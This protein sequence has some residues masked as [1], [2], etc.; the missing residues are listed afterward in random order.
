MGLSIRAKP[1]RS[2]DTSAAQA[3]AS[4]MRTVLGIRAKVE[5]SWSSDCSTDPSVAGS[6]KRITASTNGLVSRVSVSD[7]AMVC[8]Y[9][10]RAGE[11]G[12]S[13]PSP[14]RLS[15]RAFDQVVGH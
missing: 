10:E 14:R 13:R 5:A 9:R 11:A 1:L 15:S 6:V 12:T 8:G 7:M 4:R 2:N 3:R